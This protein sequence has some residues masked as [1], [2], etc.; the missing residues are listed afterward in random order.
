MLKL[1]FEK[2]EFQDRGIFLI[3]LKKMVKCWI[4]CAKMAKA[5]FLPYMCQY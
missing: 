3:S 5:N 2:M 4:F 1:D